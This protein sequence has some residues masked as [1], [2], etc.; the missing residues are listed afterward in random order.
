MQIMWNDKLKARLTK[1]SKAGKTTKEMST[2]LGFSVPTIRAALRRYDLPIPSRGRHAWKWD[3]KALTK[4]K[5]L[6]KK[7]NNKE[8]AVMFKSTPASVAQIMSINGIK[9]T[10]SR[11]GTAVR[12]S[13][14]SQASR[15]VSSGRRAV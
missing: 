1:L 2:D 14:K 4:L 5:G 9:R 6:V 7:Y 8:I 13:S 15:T 11:P 10:N 3:A 12:V